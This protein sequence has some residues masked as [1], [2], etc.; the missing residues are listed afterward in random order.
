MK[1]VFAGAALLAVLSLAACGG[2][3]E[4]KGQPSAEERRALDNIA[5]KQDAEAAETFDTSP[6]SL[7]PAEGAAADANA[8]SANETP[9][10]AA[11]PAPAADN[12]PANAAAPR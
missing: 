12:S 8:A 7:V 11:A 5:A 4:T 3:E 9:A 6:D 10:N 1:F 2:G